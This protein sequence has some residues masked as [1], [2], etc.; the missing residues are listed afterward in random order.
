MLGYSSIAHAGY[1]LLGLVTLTTAGY[2][3]SM[4]YIFGFVAMSLAAFLVICQVSRTGENLLVEDLA[5]LHKRNPLA[6]FIMGASMFSLAGIPPFVG[7]IGKFL[8]LSEAL[9][10]GFVL[11]VVLAALNTAIG[12]YYYLTVVRV[13]YFADPGD[14]P[15][16]RLDRGMAVVGVALIVL[17]TL[18]G[19][20]P[21]PL[22]HAAM[23][24]TAKMMAL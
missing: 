20:L 14:R 4:F 15:E 5:G 19:I 24:A 16:V 23:E 22:L 12:I 10:G 13:M 6:A 18:L 1:V 3:V 2:A 8:L 11:L 17:V 21:G 7:F 9:R